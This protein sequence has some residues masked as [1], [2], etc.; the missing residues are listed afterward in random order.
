MSIR[1]C[2]LA[3]TIVAALLFSA[4]FAADDPQ[5]LYLQG[6]ELFHLEQWQGSLDQLEAALVATTPAAA[7][8]PDATFKAAEC[9]YRLGDLGGALEGFRAYVAHYP[10][11]ANRR[12][13]ELRIEAIESSL[14][15]SDLAPPIVPGVL[16][17]LNAVRLERI[18]A[19]DWPTLEARL[20]ELW[21]AGFNAVVLDVSLQPGAEG[22]ALFAP[23]ER[24]GLYFPARN[25]PLVGDLTTRLVQICHKYG[26]RIFARMSTLDS[27]WLVSAEPGVADV[28]FDLESGKLMRG[29]RLDPFS[30]RALQL[31]EGMYEDLGATGVDGVL[32]A[33]DWRIAELEGFGPA[34]LAAY[35]EAYGEQLEPGSC[36]LDQSH[37][38][39]GRIHVGRYSEAFGR[40]AELKSRRL[41]Q[42]AT[43]LHAAARRNNPRCGL[44]LELDRSC[45]IDPQR[46]KARLGHDFGR[47]VQSEADYLLI[48]LH[49]RRMQAELTLTGQQTFSLMRRIIELGVSRIERPGR[50]AIELQLVDQAAFRPLPGWELEAE[51][52]AVR[53]Q[54]PVSVLLTPYWPGI[55]WH[56]LG[57]LLGN[58]PEPS[59]I[60]EDQ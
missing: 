37:D 5:A 42:I 23:A 45:L 25:A 19:R 50:L 52:F 40:F 30:E 41:M 55:K 20:L 16:E 53:S 7:F 14:G 21:R 29:Q 6:V 47:A 26:L 11:G 43:R 13:S 34:G 35:N 10:L 57:R 32:L 1:A 58:L 24:G 27:R 12:A 36:F 3:A 51:L 54:K 39:Y 59:K 4:A 56:D 48:S 2:A 33:D 22:H 28:R 38:A 46:A 44:I 31:L 17:Q 60:K 8:A 49:H 18:R 9:R 15:R